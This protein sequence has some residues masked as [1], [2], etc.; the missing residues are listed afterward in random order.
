MPEA[1]AVRSS[2]RHARASSGSSGDLLIELATHELVASVLRE[3]RV[4]PEQLPE[5]RDRLRAEV[6][7]EPAD[8]RLRLQQRGGRAGPDS[9]L[10]QLLAIVR[11]ADCHAYRML[12]LAGAD[13]GRL[14]K[15]LIERVRVRGHARVSRAIEPGARAPNG[16]VRMSAS[17][18]P[19]QPSPL[20]R[21]SATTRRPAPPSPRQS[22]LRGS[23]A[24]SSQAPAQHAPVPSPS[25]APER[26]PQLELD[27]RS[28]LQPKPRERGLPKELRSINPT[29]LP[30]MRGRER[31][32]SM[33]ADALLR[34]SVRPPV[35]VGEHGSGR[36]LLAMHLATAL[37][38]PL[39]HLDA[40]DYEDDETLTDDLELIAEA[41]GVVVFDNLD[42]VSG[43]APP[44]LLPALA[45]AWASGAPRI[46]T[47][48]SH[49]GRA[50][51]ES[52]MPGILD[53]L[54][55]LMLP[56]LDGADVHQAV[57]LASGAI[58]D[59][60]GLEL[61][62]DA[63][64]SELTRIADRF[65]T[66]LAMPGRALDL[67]DLACARTAR[68]GRVAVSHDA[69]VEVTCERTGLPRQR[70]IG[71]GERDMLDLDLRLA[72]QVVGHEHVLEILAALV[73]RNRAGFSSGRPIASVLLLGPSGVGKTEI[74]KA[75]AGAL[76]ERDDALLRLD[77]SEYAEAHAVARVVGAPP[78]YVGHEQG[79][80]LTDP[81]VR[82][83]HR[84]ILLDEIEKSHRD[85]HQLL[86]QVF[87]EGRL[88]DGRG[89][90]VDF[91]H[92]VVIMTSNLGADLMLGT[93]GG[94]LDEAD[95][96]ADDEQILSEAR[97][98][99]PVELWNRI[100]APLV[101]RPLTR[102]QMLAIC[103]RLI[104]SSSARLAHDRG[105]R[106]RVEDEAIEQ[107]IDRAGVDPALGARPLRHL[108]GRQIESLIAEQILR[109]RV[110]AG[111]EAI[112]SLDDG[113]LVVE[114][115][116]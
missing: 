111:N 71:D 12:Q 112:V 33:L 106:Y 21:G 55:V 105:I 56:P 19:A 61:A 110:R 116:R 70:I 114:I 2:T 39:F 32:L 18:G 69:W 47:I 54:D 92:A 9:E 38:R 42:R 81:M 91:R 3:V 68:E 15:L 53:T 51:L 72:R 76:Y 74:A 1:L 80:A 16:P 109:G 34:R 24:P 30:P 66:G 37:A 84:V 100:E 101:L 62:D 93:P 97:T 90:T 11:S 25:A 63:R 75:L 96:E 103:R 57:K 98:H 79:G 94:A 50:R 85:V 49:E 8:W 4:A 104:A 99:F 10:S 83:P 87:D 73:R 31:E 45:R 41:K 27:A 22:A 5:L 13:T 77:M 44:P 89:R 78:G 95:D 43:D 65:L 59:Q 102:A 14:R 58:L 7:A 113:R 64:L 17:A 28:E 20:R 48:L 108:L 26:N 82:N 52:W 67:L 115:G 40:P 29:T 88:T 23:R 35:L 6:E 107:L 86:L 60:H 46:L 36:S